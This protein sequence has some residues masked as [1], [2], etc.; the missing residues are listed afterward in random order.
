ML[1]ADATKK[2]DAASSAEAREAEHAL[3]VRLRLLTLFHAS[4]PLLQR[5]GAII[6]LRS[7]PCRCLS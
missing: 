3:A 1:L 6:I 7:K 2:P 4:L 5:G